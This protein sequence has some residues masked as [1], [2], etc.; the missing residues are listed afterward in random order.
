LSHSAS[1]FC[2]G[3][4]WDMFCFIPRLAWTMILFVLPHRVWNDRHAPPLPAYI[5]WE[6]FCPASLQLQSF[7]LCFLS[8]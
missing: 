7:N 5:D 6:R 2:V 3:Y 4:F 1:P 8:S